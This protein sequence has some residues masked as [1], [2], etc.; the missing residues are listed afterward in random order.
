MAVIKGSVL[1]ELSGR[2]GNLAARCTNGRTILSRRPAKFNTNNS[3]VMVEIRKKFAVTVSFAANMLSLPSLKDVW[4]RIT[5]S[6]LSEFNFSVKKNYALSS[7]DK[8]TVD[9][10]LTPMEGFPL[11]VTAAEVT[12][13]AVTAQI[14]PLNTVM[15]MSPDEM[16][17]TPNL[18][19]CCYNPI[20]AE[21][22]PYAVIPVTAAS[23]M[24][25]DVNPIALNV[26][27][28]VVQKAIAAKYQNTI[29]YLALTTQD[30]NGKLIQYSAT[31]AQDN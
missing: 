24:L 27:L 23:L 5:P 20:N 8:P 7:A 26:P 13:D 12:A 2:L 6:G 16:R 30:I 22:A 28:N 4:S 17:V 31:Y 25:D 11:D 21:D 14:A 19:L 1:G 3:P 29:L 15:I 9:N 18:V 10:M